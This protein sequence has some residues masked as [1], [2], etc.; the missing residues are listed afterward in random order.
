MVDIEYMPQILRMTNVIIRFFISFFITVDRINFLRLILNRIFYFR[1]LTTSPAI[2]R[3]SRPSC[4]FG[5]LRTLSESLICK[6]R[7]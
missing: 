4:C 5:R 7:H 1:L 6:K 2:A 3:Q